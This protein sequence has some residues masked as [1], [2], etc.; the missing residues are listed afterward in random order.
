MSFVHARNKKTSTAFL[1]LKERHN[2]W[3]QG[4]CRDKELFVAELVVKLT[5]AKT[6]W[7]MVEVEVEGRKGTEQ[8]L[9]SASEWSELQGWLLETQLGWCFNLFTPKSATINSE[10]KSM[11]QYSLT[12]LYKNQPWCGVSL[13]VYRIYLFFP[14]WTMWNLTLPLQF[15]DLIDSALPTLTRFVQQTWAVSW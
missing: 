2:R 8:P 13:P 15:P 5:A 11:V 1:E 12:F 10:E 7:R 4:R 14:S 9:A 6:C 3:T